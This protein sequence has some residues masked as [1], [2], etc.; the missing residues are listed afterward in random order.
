MPARHANQNELHLVN[1]DILAS[2]MRLL[3]TREHSTAELRRKLL[4]KG[5][6]Q[7]EVE[8]CVQELL[9]QNLLSDER[10]TEG[11]V[12]SRRQRGQGPLRIQRDLQ[13]H[14]IAPELIARYLDPRSPGWLEQAL[15]VR[16]K[17]FGAAMPED[18]KEKMRQ[19]RFL[20]QRGFPH[21]LIR[22]VLR[23]EA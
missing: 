22:Q 1:P 5:G 11:F 17:K 9:A 6:A 8:V 19:A 7:A 12:H 13:E 3:A 2:A 20:E 14:Q 18:Y 23:D 10:F 16:E 21:E 4:Q 15:S